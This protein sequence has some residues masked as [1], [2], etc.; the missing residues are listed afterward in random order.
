MTERVNKRWLF[1]P[2][3]DERLAAEL[4]ASIRVSPAIAGI[5]INRGITSFS[6][7]KDFFVPELTQLHDPFLMRDMDLAI[8]RLHRAISGRERILIYGD[9]DVDG[10]TAVSLVYLYLKSLNAEVSY[11][12]PD[13]N[14]EGYGVSE[15]G[16]HYAIDNGFTLVVA[17]D[18][19][20]K[21][22][23]RVAEAAKAGI[24][25]II[26]DHHLPDEQLPNA[27]A[28]LDPKRPD[29]PY[30][31]KEL[32][33]C[34]IG[35]KLVQAYAR[36]YGVEESVFR[37]LD[38]VAV[39]IAS[40]IV[41]VTGEN[42]IL[43]HFGLRRLNTDPCPGLRALIKISALQKEPD[44]NTLVFTI[45]PRIN[46]AGRVAHASA[47]VDLL[48]SRDEA[49]ADEL[50][51]KLDLTNSE[52]RVYDLSITEEALSMIDA[53]EKERQARTTV[54]YKESWHKGVVGIVAS[55]VQDKY[56]RPT[57]ILTRS[58]GKVTGSA[59][60][61]AGFDLYAAIDQCRDLLEQFGGHRHAAGLTLA[62]ENLPAFRQRFEA[63]VAATITA[64]MLQPVINIDAEV[65]LD[66]LTPKFHE[67]IQRMAP[68]GPSNPNP[69]LVAKNVQP[70]FAQLLRERHVKFQST[71]EGA[72]TRF[73]SIYFDRPEAME[74]LSGNRPVHIAFHLE[75]N[76]YNG[77]TSLQFRIKDIQPA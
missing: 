73:H 43:A 2:V 52:R 18:L 61:V 12:V 54:L 39:S 55:R 63:V 59:R 40:D 41:P 26:C 25:F 66:Q 4:S 50:A 23:G 16:I 75:E 68:F 56:Y 65:T 1:P 8:S 60:S 70:R 9:Y 10:T 36:R 19:G 5:L 72:S 32:C 14:K 46:A 48:I 76:T 69:V 22:S 38:L 49:S 74:L 30:P 51:A 11:Y 57:I 13:R 53:D 62:E 71:Q 3:P 67:V 47:A 37:Y 7:A 21:A 15:A 42:R 6:Q 58:N 45:G 29:C 44:V 17:L 35:F 24:D 28:V 20:I 64:E 34:G 33:G 31:Y 27:V 77:V